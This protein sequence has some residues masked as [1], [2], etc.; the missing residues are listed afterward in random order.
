[1]PLSGVIVRSQILH[2]WHYYPWSARSLRY[3]G[4]AFFSEDVFVIHLVMAMEPRNN[5]S[6][7]LDY[8]GA[9]N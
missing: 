1:V 8:T 7:H 9:P 2:D 6:S 5:S 4:T 3:G